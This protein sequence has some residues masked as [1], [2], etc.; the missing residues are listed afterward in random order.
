MKEFVMIYRM[1]ENP[2]FKPTPAQMQEMMTGW[3][4]WLG[5]IAAKGQL[6]DRGKRLGL[7]G[8]KTVSAG[9]VVADGPYT[10]IKEFI[11]GF[12]IVKAGSLE[13]VVEM[14]KGCPMLLGRGG[15]VEVRAVVSSDD[16]EG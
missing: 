2:D 9:N 6:V 10:E 3:M 11:N 5:G 1:T 14:A 15:R 8:G 4:N 12:S 16:F 13:E 7:K